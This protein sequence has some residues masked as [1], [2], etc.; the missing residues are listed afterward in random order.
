[1]HLQNTGLD[2]ETSASAIWQ[3]WFGAGP[4]TFELI[5]NINFTFFI[6]QQ[7][8]ARPAMNSPYYRKCRPLGEIFLPALF[9]ETFLF[10]YP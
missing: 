6:N 10:L 3:V 2:V 9:F 7:H 1:M 5:G 8:R 4:F